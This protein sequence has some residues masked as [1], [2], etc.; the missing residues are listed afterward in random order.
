MRKLRFFKLRFREW[1]QK[2]IIYN[3]KIN[4]NW[5]ILIFVTI[6][7]A[8]NLKIWNF[9]EIKQLLE[10]FYHFSKYMYISILFINLPVRLQWIFVIQFMIFILYFACFMLHDWFNETHLPSRPHVWAITLDE[11]VSQKIESNL[12]RMHC[13]SYQ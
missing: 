11:A 5:T 3:W 4:Y 8:K 6:F 13:S 7:F 10:L 2:F 9:L 1:S 12:C